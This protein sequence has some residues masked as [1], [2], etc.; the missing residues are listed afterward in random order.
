MKV[1]LCPQLP[2]DINKQYGATLEKQRQKTQH[3]CLVMHP[4][5][6]YWT[7]NWW[8]RRCESN[9]LESLSPPDRVTTNYYDHPRKLLE[10]VRWELGV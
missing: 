5:G 7:R 4:I 6:F 8:R 9:Q 3:F 10:R 1:H 2:P